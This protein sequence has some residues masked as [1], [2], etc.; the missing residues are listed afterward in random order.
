MPFGTMVEVAIQALKNILMQE[1]KGKLEIVCTS[2][3]VQ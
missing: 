2:K 1:T 3:F